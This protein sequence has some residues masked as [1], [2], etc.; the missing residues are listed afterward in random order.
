MTRDEFHKQDKRKTTEFTHK[1][2]RIE[3][4]DFDNIDDDTHKELGKIIDRLG[5]PNNYQ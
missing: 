2:T 4:Y 5:K 1:S 3:D